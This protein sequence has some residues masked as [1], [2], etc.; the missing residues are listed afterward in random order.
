MEKPLKN[1]LSRPHDCFIDPHKDLCE[2]RLKSHTVFMWPKFVGHDIYS[3]KN[4]EVK[5]C[6]A[7]EGAGTLKFNPPSPY[8]EVGR[9]NK[10][11]PSPKKCLITI[12]GA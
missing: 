5:A 4:L 2:K 3:S 1:G 12:E 11:P 8:I 10:L 9:R 7:Y 6:K